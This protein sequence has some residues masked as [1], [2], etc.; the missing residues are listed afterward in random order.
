MASLVSSLDLEENHSLS[1]AEQEEGA[2]GGFLQDVL[3][4]P[5]NEPTAMGCASRKILFVRNRNIH[6]TFDLF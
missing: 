3:N 2:E 5:A 6:V 1:S 4:T